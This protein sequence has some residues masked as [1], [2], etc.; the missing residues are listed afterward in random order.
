MIDSL[1]TEIAD[2]GWLFNNCY[3]IDATLWRVNLRR[4]ADSGDYFTDWATAPTLAEA[5]AE[6]MAKLADAEF[7]EERQPQVS[8]ASGAKPPSLLAQ[9][10]FQRPTINLRRL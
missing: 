1:L 9:L 7:E 4:P 10:G 8:K 2:S 3:Q 5:L 6:C